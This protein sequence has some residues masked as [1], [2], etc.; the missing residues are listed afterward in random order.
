VPHGPQRDAIEE[1]LA[2]AGAEDIDLRLGEASLRTTRVNALVTG[3]GPTERVVVYDNLLEL[4]P[5]QVAAVVAHEL[6]HQ[7][8]ADLLR[9]VALG[10]AAL[11]AGALVLRFV[12]TRPG[13]Q[14]TAA[15]RG[16]ADA[17]MAAVVL[18][19]LVLLE[20]AGTPIG[21][22]V[23]RRAE[24]AADAR[25]VALTRDP[26]TL[27]ATTRV[28]TVRDLSAPRPPA[29]VRLLYGTHPTVTERI[30]YLEGWADTQGVELPD[31]A[32]LQEQ[33]AAQH[34][35]AI[36]DAPPGTPGGARP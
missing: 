34:H 36:G 12:V 15:A 31:L 19:S 33:E 21:N 28:F 30:T 20:T 29:W 10:A 14:A 26:A 23:S 22:A 9:G 18:L 27:L 16:P 8:H 5:P 6:A 35:P 13:V 4:P 24:A 11:L 7:E 32:A 17:R 25:A 2:R 3:L 1:V